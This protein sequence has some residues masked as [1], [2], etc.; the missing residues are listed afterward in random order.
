MT[1]LRGAAHTDVGRV[2][3]VNQDGALTSSFLVAVADGMGG[4]R[5][6]EVAS[7]LA[8]RSLASHERFRSADEVTLAVHE[9][10]DS[11]FEA[12]AD[13]P[14]LRGMG[15][16]LCAL[17]LVDRAGAGV[18]LVLVNVGD[19]RA[20][21]MREGRLDQLTVDHSLVQLMVREGQLRPEEAESHPQRNILTR[22]LGID[23]EV[24]VDSWQLD[25]VPGDRFLICSDGLFNEVD[26]GRIA[27]T[28]R[29][30]VEPAEA[31]RVLVALANESGGRDNVTCVVVDVI[32]DDGTPSSDAAEDDGETASDGAGRRGAIGEARPTHRTDVHRVVPGPAGSTATT[33][34]TEPTSRYGRTLTTDAPPDTTRAL[35]AEDDEVL[36]HRRALADEPAPLEA[37]P[38]RFTARLVIFLFGIIAVLAVAALAVG[39]FATR[40]YYVGFDGEQVVIY[41][42]RPGGL[43]WIQPSVTE[44]PSPPLGKADL[45]AALC[46]RVDGQPSAT[47]LARARDV[48]QQL[49]A[50]QQ[51]L[52]RPATPC[53]GAA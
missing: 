5:A 28:L 30:Y 53:G 38:R 41:K 1:A 15:T 52:S 6:G 40:T 39:W 22:A 37:R 35:L 20:Y 45:V 23:A 16:T 25:P 26:V 32:D 8:L 36:A 33:D 18:Q 43:L 24:D 9:A 29:A 27:A 10:N 50:D 46:N 7:A 13:E 48:L 17:A 34:D 31:A 3:S 12:A 44:R 2:R 11:I 49:R 14:D 47:S 51:R 21:Q 19:S 4:H 42:G